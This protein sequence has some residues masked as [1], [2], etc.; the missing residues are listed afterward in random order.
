[1]SL[2]LVSQKGYLYGY[3]GQD[4]HKAQSLI[5]L[6]GFHVCPAQDANTKKFAFKIYHDS[7]CL[8]H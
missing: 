6:P 1:M 5:C 2:F 4:A 8:S 3:S 7:E